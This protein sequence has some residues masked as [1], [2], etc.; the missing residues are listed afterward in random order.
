M[1][2]PNVEKCNYRK[3]AGKNYSRNKLFNENKPFSYL[4]KPRLGFHGRAS[5]LRLLLAFGFIGQ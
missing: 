2:L 5:F 3:K 4:P 1:F